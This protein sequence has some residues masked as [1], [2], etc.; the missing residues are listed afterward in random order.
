MTAERYTLIHLVPS[1]RWGGQQSYAYD[2]CEHFKQ[3][4]WDVC[5]VTRD[6]RV[7]DSKFEK[8][9]IRLLHAPLRGFFDPASALILARHFRTIPK[10]RCIVHVHRYR[11]AFTVLLAKRLAHRFDVRLVCTR[12]CVRQGRNTWLF[13]R[14]YNKINAHIFVSQTAFDRFRNS[15]KEHLPMDEASVHILHNGININP[16]LPLPE[17]EKGPVVALYL[18][19]VVK[20][21]GLESL[22][23]ALPSLKKHKL[24]LRIA[25]QGNPDYLDSL[26]RRAMNRDVMQMID[27]KISPEIPDS[28]ISETHFAVLPSVERE[29]FGLQNI[30]VMAYGRPQICS[31]NGAQT[32]YLTNGE[33]ALFVIPG[34]T[35][36][37]AEQM[38]RLVTDKALRISMG[39]AAFAAYSANLSWDHF[40]SRLLDIYVPQDSAP[41][42]S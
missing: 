3:A 8:G 34:H 33:T 31:S 25:G 28:I 1:N 4:G 7:V 42:Q 22:I 14:I 23:D 2:I 15:W 9:G 36:L 41:P 6:A 27:W 13:R 40:I 39:E 10:G 26:R 35:A 12:H 38:E 21:K 29:A 18:G 16:G 5:A 30:R 24:R 37:L 20:G 19:G 17:P 32:E 11:D